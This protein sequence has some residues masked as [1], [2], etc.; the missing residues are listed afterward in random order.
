MCFRSF[1]C[2]FS[3]FITLSL[4]TQSCSN[5]KEKEYT[6]IP[7]KVRKQAENICNKIDGTQF[8]I[9]D[10]RVWLK[11]KDESK[12]ELKHLKSILPDGYYFCSGHDRNSQ[13]I[14]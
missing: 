2:L 8:I 12:I 1:F 9:R 7:D 4:I 10:N 6:K 3:F 5:L 13:I 14:D 11:K